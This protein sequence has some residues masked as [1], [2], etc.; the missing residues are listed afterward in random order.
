[1][2]YTMKTHRNKEVKL[3]AFL[4]SALGGGEWSASHFDIFNLVNEPSAAT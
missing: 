4:I 1:M 3:H 2:F